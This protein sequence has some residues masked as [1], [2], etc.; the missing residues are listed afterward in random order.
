MTTL[1][2]TTRAAVEA[3]MEG[4]VTDDPAA[5]DREIARAERQVDGLLKGDP[6]EATGLKVDVA[7]LLPWQASAL[8][9]AVAAQTEY[10]LQMGPAFFVE[11]QYGEVT[12]PQYTTKGRLSRIGP[13]VLEELRA[14]AD[15]RRHDPL[16]ARCRVTLVHNNATL[17]VVTAE[18]GTT[19]SWAGEQ[20]GPDKWVGLVGVFYEEKLRRVFSADGQAI[21]VTRS[22][23]VPSTLG[24]TFAVGD[25]VAFTPRS[26]ARQTGKVAAVETPRPPVGAG[27]AHRY[28]VLALEDA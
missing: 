11:D 3:Y 6:L 22:L 28:T 2:Y 19:D 21:V 18:A 24:I 16:C 20:G 4:W 5:L 25:V 9:D 14:R 17:S 8:A 7:A 23:I 10:R 15:Q 1:T 12:S 13:K 27:A 26:E